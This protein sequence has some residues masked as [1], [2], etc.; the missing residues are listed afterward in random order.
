MLGEFRWERQL[1]QRGV[2]ADVAVA[3]GRIVVHERRSRLVC[4]DSRDGTVHW[5]APVGDWPRGFVIAGDRCL[6]LTSGSH[7]LICLDLVT[8]TTLWRVSLPVYTGHVTATADTVLVGGWRDYTPLVAFDLYDGRP[9]WRTSTS[10]AAMLPLAWGGGVLLGRAREAWLL[11]PRDGSELGRWRLPEPMAVSDAATFTAVGPDRCLVPCGPRSI[12]ALRLS[13]GAVDR[14]FDHHVDLV[15][16]ATEFT[17]GIV[18][19]R[20][21]RAGYLAVDPVRG[22]TMCRVDV[23]QPLVGGIVPTGPG[24]VLAGENGT[25]YRVGADGVVVGRLSVTRRIAALA[26]LGTGG[27]VMVTKGTLRAV[28]SYAPRAGDQGE[29]ACLGRTRATGEPAGSRLPGRGASYDGRR[30][31][32]AQEE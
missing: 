4:L 1:H 10:V 20:E 22:S 26:D 12:V 19:V 2:A 7:Q 16:T 30:P 6:V 23:G 27:L 28:E 29:E 17:A 25:L 24:F 9:L 13:S 8:G 32:V 5:D 18:W 31:G 15:V 3:Q 11:H 21:R 14:F